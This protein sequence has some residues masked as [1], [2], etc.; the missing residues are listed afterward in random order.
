MRGILTFI[1]YVRNA[2]R[3]TMVTVIKFLTAC[4]RHA[5]IFYF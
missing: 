3:I 2:R 5:V 1:V 4:L